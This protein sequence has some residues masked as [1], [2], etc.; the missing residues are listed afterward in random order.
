MPQAKTLW[1]IRSSIRNELKGGWDIDDTR[2]HDRFIDDK[3]HDARNSILEDYSRSNPIDDSVYQKDCC[4]EIQCEELECDGIL[5]GTKQYYVNIKPLLSINGTTFV[6]YVGS[7]DLKHSA[8]EVPLTAWGLEDT[9]TGNL[10]S[11]TRVTSDKM[12]LRNLPTQGM[13][14]LCVIAVFQSPE[15]TCTEWK[16]KAYPIPGSLIRKLEYDVVQI[17]I[18]PFL[19]SNPIQKNDAADVPINNGGK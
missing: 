5:T 9:W 3:I 15:I 11:Y 16:D 6:R 18:K 4:L 7:V 12:I 17:L 14:Y 19:V 2:I 8:T 10:F 1:S 13:K